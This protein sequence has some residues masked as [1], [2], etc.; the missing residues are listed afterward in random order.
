MLNYVDEEMSDDSAQVKNGKFIFTG[1]IDSDFRHAYFERTGTDDY[2]SVFIENQ[3]MEIHL[4][5][6]KFDRA[7]L[8]GSPTSTMSDLFHDGMKDIVAK[9]DSLYSIETIEGTP[10]DDEVWAQIT[11]LDQ[12][13]NKRTFKFIEAHEDE[14][15]A[16][17]L[18][19]VYSRSMTVG[20]V[21]HLYENFTPE[22][23]NNRYGQEVKTF[24]G[25]RKDVSIGGNYADF[26]S[27]DVERNETKLSEHLGQKLTLVDFWASWCAPCRME[28]PSVVKA[29]KK[30]HE[31]GLEVVG[32]SLDEKSDRWMKAIEKD[33]LPWIQISELN[34]WDETAAVMYG[35]SGIPDNF[36]IDADG[37]ILAR[38][39]RGDELI[40]RI[41]EL[42]D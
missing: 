24:L 18:L 19:N 34:G 39:L 17:F 12:E 9:S 38:G 5:P 21:K 32:V 14:P 22:V 37:K 27:L 15:M 35:V 41:G 7:Q 30:Y 42:L 31:K 4:R 16:A 28:N 13:T 33:G 2:K 40:E 8:I 3:K 29:Y 11:E 20:S 1:K 26:T 10:E 36:L 25:L 23:Q 6:G